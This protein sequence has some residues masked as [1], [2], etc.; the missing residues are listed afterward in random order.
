MRKKVAE[1]RLKVESVY[2]CEFF[3]KTSGPELRF[4]FFGEVIAEQSNY[5]P[6]DYTLG[7]S[8]YLV[9]EFQGEEM[10]VFIKPSRNEQHLLQLTP[11]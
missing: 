9:C 5:I 6:F 8:F 1:I 11:L 3:E 2:R 4:S 7:T 10:C